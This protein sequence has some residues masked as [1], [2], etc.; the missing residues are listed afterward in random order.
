MTENNNGPTPGQLPSAGW[1]PDPAR[2]DLERYW[3]G[4]AWTGHVRARYMG[5]GPSA[6]IYTQPAKKR[7]GGL[8]AL[9]L[10]AILVALVA[11]AGHQGIL[12]EWV[13]FRAA[14]VGGPPPTP[15]V[16][17]PVMGSDDLVKYLAASMID[18]KKS[19]DV[20]YWANAEGVGR[21][22]VFDAV[23]EAAIQNPY[24]FVRGWTYVTSLSG[25]TLQPDY[26]YPRAEARERQDETAAAVAVG[27]EELDLSQTSSDADKARAIHDYVASVATY[28]YEAAD[29]IGEG[30]TD[31]TQVDQS[32][33]AY[34]ILVAGT[35]VCNG[36]AQAFQALA[37]EVGLPTVVVTGEA[38][39][40]LTVGAHAWN[41][42]LVDGE[43]D[44]V[45]VTWDDVDGSYVRQD[46]FLVPP[47]DEKL[48]S[49]TPDKEWVVDSEAANYGG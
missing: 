24:L 45:D 28:D 13:P 2:T 35:A 12:P 32:Q 38:N 1:L 7:R 49:R 41:R 30:E 20:T 8:R 9:V 21:D 19:I 39:S 31:S 42:V 23:S 46:Y 34:G 33:E 47:G 29:A 10:T 3:D 14:L 44:V 16:A 40:G 15:E 4:S 48:D 27:L 26:V 37:Y 17:Y 22:G 18:Q 6:P 25:V 36:Y 43:W 5:Y 11:V